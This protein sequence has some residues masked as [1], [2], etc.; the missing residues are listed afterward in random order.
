MLY[1]QNQNLNK[2]YLAVDD[3]PVLQETVLDWLA[4]KLK[5]PHLEKIRAPESNRRVS[6]QAIKNLE[7]CFRY[8]SYKDGYSEIIE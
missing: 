5:Q 1:Q 4:E 8:P 6:N 2:I 7:N 3:C